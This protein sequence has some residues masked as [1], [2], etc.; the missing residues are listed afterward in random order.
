MSRVMATLKKVISGKG[1]WVGPMRK[2]ERVQEFSNWERFQKQD[3]TQK[4]LKL[5][6]RIRTIGAGKGGHSV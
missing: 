4:L 2:A 6:N 5:W 1:N 3:K